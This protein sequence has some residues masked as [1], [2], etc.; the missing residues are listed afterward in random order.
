MSHPLGEPGRV[1][2]GA[3]C[4]RVPGDLRLDYPR[5]AP[6]PLPV[7]ED[8]LPGGGYRCVV[9]ARHRLRRATVA[10]RSPRPLPVPTPTRCCRHR[11][12]DPAPGAVAISSAAGLHLAR[13]LHPRGRFL[14][15]GRVVI[16][17]PSNV[18]SE[19]ALSG[20]GRQ[21]AVVAPDGEVDRHLQGAG[22]RERQAVRKRYF[23]PP[24]GWQLAAGG[25][26]VWQGNGG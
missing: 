9:G 25:H 24:T 20:N 5:R 6:T 16:A 17:R 13:A 12:A 14:S 2:A 26:F 10:R 21:L 19:P 4:S 11:V 18:A 1:A 23:A 22:R 3:G 7:L 15:R 8:R